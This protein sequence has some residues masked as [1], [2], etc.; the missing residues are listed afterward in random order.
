MCYIGCYLFS[1]NYILLELYFH[2]ISFLFNVVPPVTKNLVRGKNGPGGP[3][4]VD[5]ICS[6]GGPNLVTKIGPAQPK[7]VRCRKFTESIATNCCKWY[8]H[9]LN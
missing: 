9:T 3:F 4:L 6:G 8:G 1:I 2:L 5:K 7:M